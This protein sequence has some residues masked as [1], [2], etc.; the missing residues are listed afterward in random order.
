MTIGVLEQIQYT[1]SVRVLLVGGGTMVGSTQRATGHILRAV[2]EILKEH[3]TGLAS[4]Q[5]IQE[6][7]RRLRQNDSEQID[8]NASDDSR[9]LN[10]R[11]HSAT[12]APAKAGWLVKNRGH[13]KLTG[14]G[15]HA[16]EKYSDPEEFA[17]EANRASK[18]KRG[19]KRLSLIKLAA[20]I[21]ACITL[22][23]GGAWAVG[24]FTSWRQGTLKGRMAA[25][26]Q[27]LD[28]LTANV[29]F[30][31]FT[32]AFGMQPQVCHLRPAGRPGRECTFTRPF[33]YVKVT[34]N[35]DDRVLQYAVTVHSPD[36]TPTFSYSN[37]EPDVVLGESTVA[38]A[39]GGGQ[40]IL[41]FCAAS[42]SGYYEAWGG[43]HAESYRFHTIGVNYLGASRHDINCD[44]DAEV[45][46]KYEVSGV[47]ETL[48]LPENSPGFRRVN[49]IAFSPS[50]NNAGYL[51]SSTGKRLRSELVVNTFAESAPG[52][53]PLDLGAP[54]V[55]EFDVVDKD[56]PKG[57]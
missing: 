10:R 36:F 6:V 2:F 15:L 24:H 33:E 12:I 22:W 44:T 50:S 41:A 45:F 57:A 1:S 7:A 27:R 11:I 14:K 47:D 21:G 49:V 37:G 42:R 43:S 4:E 55:E 26:Q 48:I 5:I 46:V 18:K 54:G 17:H 38:Q 56:H 30:S 9:R 16:Y 31:V 52:V 23:T 28:K 35:K 20:I 39:S 32:D 51:E 8:P 19:W 25:E 40:Y 29:N 34:L 3:P 53:E 13:W